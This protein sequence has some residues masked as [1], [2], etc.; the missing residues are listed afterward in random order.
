MCFAVYLM[1]RTREKRA[2]DKPQHSSPGNVV[3]DILGRWMTAADIDF[4]VFCVSFEFY[5]LFGFVIV[6]VIVVLDPHQIAL[7]IAIFGIDREYIE[8]EAFAIA[9]RCWTA[10]KTGRITFGRLFH[11]VNK[12]AF[13]LLVTVQTVNNDRYGG[14]TKRITFGR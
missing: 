12:I 9:A 5:G 6:L 14:R 10:P 2:T 1:G 11:P 3:L 13:I 4:P 8:S 7:L